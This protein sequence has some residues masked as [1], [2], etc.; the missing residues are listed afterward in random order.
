MKKSVPDARCLRGTEELRHRS[1]DTLMRTRLFPQIQPCRPGTAVHA[2]CH[3]R[4]PTDSTPSVWI[5]QSVL[6]FLYHRSCAFCHRPCRIE[7]E[8]LLELLQGTDTV[9]L[10]QSD[11]P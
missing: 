8:I 3:G 9:T 2:T 1:S 4:A 11:I 5:G 7:P 10:S 6:E